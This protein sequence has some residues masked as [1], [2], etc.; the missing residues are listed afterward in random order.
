MVAAILLLV[1][2][3]ALGPVASQ[4]PAAVLA[5]ILITV[6][7]GVMDYKG[8]KAIPN[9]PGSEVFIMLVVLVLSVFWN[10]VFA[11]GIGL[12]LAALVFMKKIGDA[13]AKRSKLVPLGIAD[14]LQQPWADEVNFPKNLKE[15]VF[16]KRLDGPLFF[17][18]TSDFQELAKGIPDTASHVIIRMGKV[19][20]ID[21]SGLYALED[22]LMRF[23]QAGIEVHF[24]NVQR[25]PMVMMENIDIVPDLVPLEHIFDNFQGAMEW[26]KSNV[27]DTVS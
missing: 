16:I 12:V 19:D 21:Q 8:L 17:G 3:L 5:G 22:A 1:I 7:I 6:G 9:M 24:V 11:V 15:E 18:N 13:S 25:Q 23:S 27:E 26:I 2:L 4:I 14:E 10:L 20:Y